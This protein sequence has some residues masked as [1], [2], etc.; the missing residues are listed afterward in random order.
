MPYN[1]RVKAGVFSQKSTPP[2]MKNLPEILFLNTRFAWEGEDST[3]DPMPEDYRDLGA[4]VT[5]TEDQHLHPSDPMYVRSDL[6]HPLQS[7]AA[8]YRTLSQLRHGRRGNSASF[9]LAVAYAAL[10]PLEPG[11][12]LP[13]SL[14]DIGREIGFVREGNLQQSLW[15]VVR[16]TMVDRGLV[17]I[18]QTDHAL[19]KRMKVNTQHPAIVSIRESVPVNSKPLL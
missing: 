3:D 1:T 14:S 6:I 9:M 16:E 15:Q 19:K 5:H 11:D 13:G 2:Q 17:E 8:I 12:L 18:V 10:T 7:I 4:G